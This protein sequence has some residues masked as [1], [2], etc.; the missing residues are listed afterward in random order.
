[1]SSSRRRCNELSRLP[2]RSAIARHHRLDP[3][4]DERLTESGQFPH[5]TGNR[6]EELSGL[7]PGEL[8]GYLHDASAA[9]GQES[10]AEVAERYASVIAST[11][12]RPSST[13]V[14]VGHQDPVQAA[15]LRLTG[16]D[17]SDLRC[18]PPVH[19]EVITLVRGRDGMWIETE[20]WSPS[21]SNG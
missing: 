19:G 15:R 10:L 14:L 3:V 9:T 6:W 11:I 21:G 7:F 2:Q 12:E 18:D 4:I 8:D 1:M 17:L 16:R 20:R 13:I 5:W